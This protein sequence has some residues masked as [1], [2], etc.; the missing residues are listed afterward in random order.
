MLNPKIFTPAILAVFFLAACGDSDPPPAPATD[1]PAADASNDN[2][3]LII[4]GDYVVTM[5]DDGT[6]IE[7]GAVAIDGGVI[8]AIDSADTI[9][10]SYTANGHLQGDGRWRH[11]W[12]VAGAYANVSIFDVASHDELHELLSGLPLFPYLTIEVT[13]LAAHPSAIERP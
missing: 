7:S 12:R 6:V 5:D 8:V 11:L 3:D 9:N 10:A 2:I 4:E 1:Q 13:P